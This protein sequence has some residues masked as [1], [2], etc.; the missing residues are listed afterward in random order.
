MLWRGFFCGDESKTAMQ[1]FK[2]SL[3]MPK[4]KWSAYLP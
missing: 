3:E 4:E 1:T 2:D